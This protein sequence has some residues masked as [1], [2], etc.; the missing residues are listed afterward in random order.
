[1]TNCEIILKQNG[2][3]MSG[4]LGAILVSQFGLIANTASKTIVRDK[5][6]H[7]ITGFYKSG[8]HFCFLEEHKENADFFDLFQESLLN[9]G[10]KYWYCLNALKMCGGIISQKY[11]ECYTNYPI[12]PLKSHLPFKEVLQKFVEQEILIFNGD[13]YLLSPK[14]NKSFTNYAHYAT[15]EAIKEAVLDNFNSLARNIGLISFNTGEFFPEYGKF[16]FG[17]KGVSYVTGLMD[18]VKNGYVVADILIGHPVY[19]NDVKFFVDKLNT[20]K[21]FEKSSRLMPFLIVDDLDPEALNLLKSNGIVVGFIKELFGEKYA[22][23]LIELVAILNNAGA[24]LK[25][26]PEKYL[27]LINELKTYN[28]GLA[29]N[30]KG[31]LFEFVVGHIHSVKCQNL[32]LGR[33]IVDAKGKHETDVVS[34]YSDKIVISECKATKSKIDLKTIEKWDSIKIPAFYDWVKGIDV[35]REKDIIFE[36][37]SI[38]GFTDEALERLHHLKTTSKRFKVE[39]YNGDDLK[40][41]AIKMKNKKLKEVVDN[42]FLKNKV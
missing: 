5:K 42:F 20:I 24:S 10:K 21:Q 31:T 7:R 8:Q 14:Y 1:M 16:R 22:N 18:G 41:K 27:D 25:K 17:F 13:R 40:E 6:I 28:K 38:S 29:N 32:D 35:Y 12:I 26:T 34:V 2:P 30:I 11:L 23:T 3:L 33:E 36:Y 39:Y 9:N 15:I 4:E 37:W 19:E